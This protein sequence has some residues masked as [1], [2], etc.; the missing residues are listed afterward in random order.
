MNSKTEET[1]K[2][3]QKTGPDGLTGEFY[4]I[5]KEELY[6]FSTVSSRRQKQR[7][8]ILTFYEASITLI[9]KPDECIIRKLQTNILYE[10]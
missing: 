10:Y 6:Q 7:E 1:N 5:F 9:S 2:Q 3:N 8:Y 4:K